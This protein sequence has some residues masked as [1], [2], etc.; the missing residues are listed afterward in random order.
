MDDDDDLDFEREVVIHLY[1]LSRHPETGV[2]V[3]Q[4]IMRGTGIHDFSEGCRHP[5]GWLPVHTGT[6]SPLH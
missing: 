5:V 1:E 4:L 6:Q 2:T 3:E